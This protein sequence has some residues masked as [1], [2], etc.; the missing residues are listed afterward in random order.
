MNGF[1]TPLVISKKKKRL[2]KAK[3]TNKK[4]KTTNTHTYTIALRLN[5]LGK[6]K[7]FVQ[8]QV[9]QQQQQNDP[10]LNIF[11]H[12]FFQCWQCEYTAR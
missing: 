7:Q 6:K 12:W 10:K 9:G 11:C 8:K 3:Q 2:K 4:P 1:C 5:A